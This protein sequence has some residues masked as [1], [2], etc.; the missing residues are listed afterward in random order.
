MYYSAVYIAYYVEVDLFMCTD[1]VIEIVKREFPF[2][3]VTG[4]KSESRLESS[5]VDAGIESP[6]TLST[7]LNDVVV[8]TEAGCLLQG[9]G[10]LLPTQSIHIQSCTWLI[11]PRDAL[12]NYTCK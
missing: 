2:A 4:V 1:A 5:L 10:E 3:S 8:E 7:D 11:I 12:H 9:A 6:L